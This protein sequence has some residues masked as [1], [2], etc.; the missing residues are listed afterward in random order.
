M[1]QAADTLTRRRRNWPFA[2]NPLDPLFGA[3]ITGITLAD[4]DGEQMFAHVY[5]AFLDYQ[6]ILFRHVD[7]PPAVQVA[8]A[9]R[10]GEVQVHAMN[11]YHGYKEHPEIYLLTNLDKDGKPN[12]KHPDL[13][14]LHWHTDGSWR[15]RTGHATMMY[16]EVVPAEGGK[17]EFADMYSAYAV[18]PASWKAKI[19]GR[20]AIHNLDFSR[21][22]RHGLDPLSAEQRAKVPPVAHPIVRTHPESGRTAMFLGDHAE[23]IE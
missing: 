14:T 7:L 11:Q 22:R 2:V 1:L 16:S 6:L 18:L 12:G 17:T 8:F 20:R 15:E 23:S 4:A 5:E 21:T 19:E 13:G 10:F 3:E 9:R